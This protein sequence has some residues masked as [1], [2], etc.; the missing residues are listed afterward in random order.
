LLAVSALA[1]C[2]CRPPAVVRRLEAANPGAAF[3]VSVYGC[4][5]TGESR[6]R[7]GSS[8]NTALLW[9]RETVRRARYFPCS[10]TIDAVRPGER[11][12]IYKLSLQRNGT[13]EEA[14]VPRTP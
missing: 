3:E 12:P 7:F 2:A 9:S 14:V 1:V 11:R 4:A 10:A 5:V 8:L 6:R 13:Y